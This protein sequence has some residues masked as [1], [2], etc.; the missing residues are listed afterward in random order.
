MAQLRGV[1]RKQFCRFLFQ[2]CCEKAEYFFCGF[3][4]TIQIFVK[5]ERFECPEIKIYTEAKWS[6]LPLAIQYKHNKKIES[7]EENE[8]VEKTRSTKI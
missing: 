7:R 3:F 8:N 6:F 1:I 2:V 4:F 5:S